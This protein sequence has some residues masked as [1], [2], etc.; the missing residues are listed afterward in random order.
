M[1]SFSFLSNIDC[2][3]YTVQLSTSWSGVACSININT[4]HLRG[5]SAPELKTFWTPAPHARVKAPTPYLATSLFEAQRGTVLY[6]TALDAQDKTLLFQ[7]RPVHLVGFI[8]CVPGHQVNVQ[9]NWPQQQTLRQLSDH[10]ISILELELELELKRPWPDLVF[11]ETPPAVVT[12][13][14]TQSNP[15]KS[16][17]KSLSQHVCGYK[18]APGWRCWP[19][20]TRRLFF[21]LKSFC[22][23]SHLQIDYPHQ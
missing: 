7:L 10:T 18:E 17:P 1:L 19:S 3:I 21:F 12:L 22:L 20:V 14:T 11:T 9:L 4:Q 2:T 5:V 13:H 15:T 6:V 8:I 16:N 23:A